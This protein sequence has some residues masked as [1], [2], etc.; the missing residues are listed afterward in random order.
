MSL[1]PRSVF[2]RTALA[3]SGMLLLG[4]LATVVLFLLFFTRP[5]AS[6]TGEYLGRQLL[7]I[8]SAVA[9][10]DAGERTKYIEALAAAGVV[11]YRSVPAGQMPPGTPAAN[12]FQQT[13]AATI[14][15]HLAQQVGIR[16]QFSPVQR[17]VWVNLPRIARTDW[18]G[19]TL[20]ENG[21]AFPR[22]LLAQL[23]VIIILTLLGS[24]W[25]AYRLNRPIR[26]LATAVRQ[27]GQGDTAAQVQ[28]TGPRE[29]RELGETFN[30]MVRDINKLAEDR[31]LLL[32]GVS[33]DLRTPLSRLRLAL[34]MLDTQS[35]QSLVNGMVQDLAE[36]DRILE[37]FMAYIRQGAEEASQA[38]DLNSMIQQLA[39]RY[40]QQG[41]PIGLKLAQLPQ[42]RFKPIAMQRLL[43]NLIDNAWEYGAAPVE[44]LTRVVD[45]AIEVCVCDRGPGLPAGEI[46]HLCQPFTRKDPARSQGLHAGLGLAIVDRIVQAHAGQLRVTNREGGGLAVCVRL[47]NNKSGT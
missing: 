13:M 39:G 15:Q 23:A 42:V 7:G 28:P 5:I 12:A 16:F 35:D 32:A 44:I 14:T 17:V 20:S 36:M 29:L 21:N 19:L 47:P 10:F 26:H 37:Q 34:E 41:K 22:S 2:A 6:S 38:G 46:A 43:G 1:W 9:R 8:Q 27:I 45:D 11:Q 30:H 33:H 3:F 40:E 31:N 25:F 18:F 4:Y 24:L